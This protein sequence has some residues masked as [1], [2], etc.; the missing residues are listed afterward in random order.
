[1]AYELLFY[2]TIG[3]IVVSVAP[4]F[5]LF[6]YVARRE[7][8]LWLSAVMGGAFWL[9][10][11]IARLPILIPLQLLPYLLPILQGPLLGLTVMAIIIVAALCAGLFEEGFKYWLVSRERHLI[12]TPKHVVC[13]GLGWGLTE[14]LL[15]VVPNYIIILLFLPLIAPLMGAEVEAASMMLAGA[16]ERD[17]AIIAHVAFSALVAIA[18]WREDRTWLGIAIFLH[19]LF[20]FIAVTTY[21]TLIQFYGVIPL[22]LW[23]TESLIAA[24][25]VAIAIFTHLFWKRQT[26]QSISSTP[27]D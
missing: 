24:M 22:A 18:V 17:S 4:A 23:I 10:A 20:D 15:L 16:L 9:L 7:G 12:E 25:A 3:A 5:A 14:A 19:F 2:A 26:S 21:R 1:M 8:S 13:L 27:E 6:L 11:L